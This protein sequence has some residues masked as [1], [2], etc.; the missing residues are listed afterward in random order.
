LYYESTQNS[1]GHYACWISD[2]NDGAHIQ[3]KSLNGCPHHIQYRYCNIGY[4]VGLVGVWIDS[5]EIVEVGMY[6]CAYTLVLTLEF[7]K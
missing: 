5:K 7:I 4:W 2:N 3:V 1:Q 6:P